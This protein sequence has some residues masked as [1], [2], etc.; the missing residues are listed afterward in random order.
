MAA[1]CSAKLAPAVYFVDI[2]TLPGATSGAARSSGPQSLPD[3]AA[4]PLTDGQVWRNADFG[5]VLPPGPNQAIVGDSVRFDGCAT[6][7]SNRERAGRSQSTICATPIGGGD[8]FAAKTVPTV[9]FC[10]RRAWRLPRGAADAA[11][12]FYWL[13]WR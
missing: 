10:R 4:L 13:P 7:V 5:Y 9:V 12:R 2:G 8:P 1:F 3:L 11:D 6:D